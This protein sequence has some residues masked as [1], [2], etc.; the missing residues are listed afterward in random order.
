M[1]IFSDHLTIIYNSLRIYQNSL[2]ISINKLIFFI[3]G[4]DVIN[5]CI[6]KYNHYFRLYEKQ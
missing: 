6:I 1:T 4:Q 2:F 5:K 3:F